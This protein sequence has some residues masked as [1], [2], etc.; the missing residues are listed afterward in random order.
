MTDT[1]ERIE[2]CA[3]W[4]DDG[5]AEVR[6]SY[7]EWQHVCAGGKLSRAGIHYRECEDGSEEVDAFGGL[8]SSTEAVEVDW[9]F[10]ARKVYATCHDGTECYIGSLDELD[11]F[12]DLHPHEEVEVPSRA[13]AIRRL[14]KIEE[15]C[16]DQDL[17]EGFERC[18]ICK[19]L[20]NPGAVDH[21]EHFFGAYWDG[22]II[23]SDRVAAFEEVWSD[24]GALI[25]DEFDV[26][27][28]DPL[29]VCRS[30]AVAHGLAVDFLATDPWDQT[31]ASALTSLLSFEEGNYRETGGMLSG[32]G[33]NLY[34]ESVSSYDDLVARVE[35][36]VRIARDAMS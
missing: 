6:M 10:K 35:Q 23:W 28:E 15:E 4:V 17:E 27:C 18:P 36:F 19:R 7:R 34:L 13:E 29:E 20:N 31:T 21:C 14:A 30:L 26:E 1:N 2:L 24:L 22:E 9:S 33:Y 8:T 12:D 16:D 5:E 3:S 25:H 32:S 11:R